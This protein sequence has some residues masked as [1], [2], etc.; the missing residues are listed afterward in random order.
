[1]PLIEYT[2]DGKLLFELADVPSTLYTII[3]QLML[4]KR[5]VIFAPY[6]RLQLVIRK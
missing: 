6:P 3:Q 5:F 4:R 2:L 1:M